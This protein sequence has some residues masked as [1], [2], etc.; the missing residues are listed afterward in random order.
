MVRS[1]DLPGWTLSGSGL[2][3]L[4]S[5]F[6]RANELMLGTNDSRAELSSRDECIVSKVFPQSIGSIELVVIGLL[7]RKIPCKIYWA[8][9]VVN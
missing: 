5:E 4:L 6:C 7:E 2:Q 3:S 1:T 8:L 9:F